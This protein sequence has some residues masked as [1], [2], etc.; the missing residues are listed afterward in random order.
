MPRTDST[1]FAFNRGLISPLALGRVD[2]KRNALSAE[3]SENWMPRTL[4]SM[5]LRPGRAYLG[6]TASNAAARYIPFVRSL[7]AMHLLEFTASVM[8][9][10]TSDA[11]LTRPA[12][13]SA[14]TNGT[15]TTNLTGWTD[16]DE[17]GATSAWD[18]AQMSL[19]GT[20]TAAA[21]RDQE[22]I[23]IA[24]DRGIEHALRIV[25]TRGPVF[26]RVGTAIGDDSYVNE[27]A[28]G[29][30]THSISFTPT[31]LSFWIRFFSRDKR[32]I[33][34]DSC[35]VESSGVVSLPAPYTATDLDNIRANADSLS[36]DVLFVGCAGFQ[37]RRIER[38]TAGRSWSVVLYQPTDGPFRSANTTT[39]TLT[40][41]TLSGNGTLVSS[42][43]YFRSTHVGALFKVT[44]VGQIVTVTVTAQNTFTN[45]VRITGV[46]ADR[47]FVIV[48]DSAGVGTT[49][50]L[51]SSLTSSTGPWSDVTSKS[52]TTATNET[53]TD[54]L[55]N[56]IV[57][58][59]I[60]CK[61]GEYGAGTIIT[62]LQTNFGAID[63]VCRLT[64]YTS[65]TA[66]NMEVLV[67]F[68]GVTATDEWAEGL[69]S[70]YRGWPSAG[71]LNEGRMC[72]AGLDQFVGSVSDQFDGFDPATV[73]DSGP[74]NRTIGSGPMDTINWM[75]PLGRLI[76]GAQLAEHSIRSTAL[77]EPIT[78]TNFNRKTCST[79]G[80]AGVQAVKIDT[81]GA[82]VQRGGN[83][84]FELGPDPDAYDYKSTDLTMLN[85]DVLKPRVVRMDVQRRPDTRIHCVLSDGTVAV[86]V[87]DHAEQVT[88]WIKITATDSTGTIE[89]VVVLPGISGSY[90]DQ[91]YYQTRRVIN[92]STV[93][94]LEKW[95]TEDECIG[96]TLNKQAD[97]YVITGAGLTT[98]TGLT[99]LIGASV[100]VWGNGKDLGTYTVSGAGEITVTEALDSNGAVVGLGYTADWKSAKLGQTIGRYKNI[101]HIAPVLSYTHARGLR[102]G[103]SF[104]YL[105]Y[106]PL[107]YQGAAVSVDRIYT[108]FDE[109]PFEF[110]GNWSTDARICL[111]AAAPRPA[112]VLCFNI[113]GQVSE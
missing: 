86:M 38:R 20:G 82:F 62:T 70:D 91:V 14:V 71:T 22:V 10:W 66:M 31:G 113:D 9:I 95:A 74:I 83:R 56:Q 12:V 17:A 84:L 2:L 79:Q 104:D 60:G 96:G 102:V 63:G 105:D 5:M 55:D 69:W 112:C 87:Y 111:R 93:R 52:W 11:L 88:C 108:T 24:A 21:I 47:A 54:G 42:V 100:V 51:Q 37:Q 49:I 16:S 15:F 65:A 92:G 35:D 25:V 33:L 26:L 28:L 90:E 36:V 94:F 29:A 57:W 58:Y 8:R 41:S 107:E 73:G 30:G 6:N 34:V 1:R 68:G 53:F 110:P 109:Q 45:A 39:A 97:A 4:G 64:G 43:N 23:C 101:D 103:S 77:D 76:M 99:H 78:P 72:W 46:G 89:D 48:I 67:E 3:T 85:P 81:R 50:R 59:R 61:T 13:S 98:I 7:S 19:V 44:S 32:N 18:T 80:S 27:V 75:L 106:L 40:P